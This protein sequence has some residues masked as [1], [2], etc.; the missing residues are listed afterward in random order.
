MHLIA[1]MVVL[2]NRY[3]NH[4]DV[5]MEGWIAQPMSVSNHL[6]DHS[7]TYWDLRSRHSKQMAMTV[8]YGSWAV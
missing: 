5:S 2:A 3:G 1:R 6:G 4:L 7:V 8:E